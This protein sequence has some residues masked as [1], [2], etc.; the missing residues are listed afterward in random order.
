VILIPI[1]SQGKPMPFR[2][3]IN[4]PEGGLNQKSFILCEMIRSVDK[5]RLVR[6]HGAVSAATMAVV[7][8]Q[9]RILLAL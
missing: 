8:D 7:E 2:V 5:G 6:R 9:V 3:E 1:T 4:P